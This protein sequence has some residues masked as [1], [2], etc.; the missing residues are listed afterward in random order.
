MACLV[1]VHALTETDWDPDAGHL[2]ALAE[3]SGGDSSRR[4][5]AADNEGTHSRAARLPHLSIAGCTA[6]LWLSAQ[7]SRPPCLV[8]EAMQ[9]PSMTEIWAVESHC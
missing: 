8:Y 6:G 9:H 5:G 3:E 1:D 2:P 7:P 4:S